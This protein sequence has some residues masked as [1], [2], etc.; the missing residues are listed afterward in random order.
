MSP[1]PDPVEVAR[2]AR[3]FRESKYDIKSALREI[4][5]SDAFH[6]PENR[7]VLVK[8]P[9]EL[10]VGTLRQLGLAPDESLPFAVAA[11]AMGQNLMAPPNVKGWP[12]GEAWINTTT[13]LARKHYLDRLVRADDGMPRAAMPAEGRAM[14]AERDV[15]KLASTPQGVPDEATRRQRFLRQMERG[16]ASLDF[17]SAR[18]MAQFPGANAADRERAA[19]RLLLA[20]APQASPGLP[21]DSLTFV[22]GIDAG[23]KICAGAVSVDLTPPHVRHHSE[24]P[25]RRTGINRASSRWRPTRRGTPASA[26]R[27]RRRSSRVRARFPFRTRPR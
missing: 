4:L 19:Q 3:R 26:A 7:G 5:T 13:L 18:W 25:R 9:V 8:S 1:D 23:R 27:W 21:A 10:V 22:R 16:L 12:G 17:D 6:A 11:T 20:T 14:E 15:P 2:I 24:D